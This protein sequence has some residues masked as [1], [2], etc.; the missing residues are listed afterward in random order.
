VATAVDVQGVSKRF[1]LYHRKYTSLKERVIHAGR[2]PYTDLWALRDISFE[3]A[4]GQTVGI[5]G[6]NGSGKSTLLKCICGVLQ[7]TNGQVVVEGKLAGLL[8]LGAGF[9]PDLTGRQNIYLNGSLLGLSRVDIDR[10]FDDIVAFAELEQFIDQQVKFYS[11]GMYVRLGFAVA[12]NVDPD[13]LVIDEV[14][15]VGDERF[16]RKCLDRVRQF[17]VEGR[18]IIFVTHSP[19]QVRSICDKA[20]VLS[21]GQAIGYGTPGEVIR[22]FRENLQNAGDSLAAAFVEAP[23]EPQIPIVGEPLRPQAVRVSGVSITHPG[24]GERP[25][26][27]TGEPLV[28]SVHFVADAP[29]TTASFVVEIDDEYGRALVRSASSELGPP[30]SLAAGP[31]TVTFS[32]PAIPFTDGAYDVSVGIEHRAGGEFDDWKEGVATIEVMN[33]TKTLGLV[34]LPVTVGL[35]QEGAS[36]GPAVAR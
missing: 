29:T 25:Y 1:R 22:L 11:S 12:I 20:V 9:Q 4:E 2:T 6:R 16:Q 36:L 26:V 14:L 33:P 30:L 34:N 15:A 5:L 3:V 17:Q 32:Y 18:T 31:G 24:S 28:L 10:V 35:D 19:D 27:V 21:D 7:P 23:S 13:V 8:E